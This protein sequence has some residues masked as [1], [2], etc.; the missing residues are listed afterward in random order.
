MD[1]P[2]STMTRAAR[3]VACSPFEVE[4]FMAMRSHSISLAEIAGQPG[5]AHHYTQVPLSE[6]KAESVLVWLIDVGLLRREVDGQGL[7]DSFRLT[8]LGRK[9]L[10]LWQQQQI[11]RPSLTDYWQNLCSRWVRWPI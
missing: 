7:T 8:P 5:V 3:A 11:P 10:Q 9:L 4:L 2:R 1:Y 6:P